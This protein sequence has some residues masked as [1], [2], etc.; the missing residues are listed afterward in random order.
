MSNPLNASDFLGLAAR[1]KTEL[2]DLS[3]V[4]RAGGV[5]IRELTAAQR[6][7][8]M[9]LGGLVTVRPDNSTT[10]DASMLTTGASVRI[11]AMSLVTDEGGET[12]M[13]KE[14][15]REHGSKQKA[16]NTLGELPAA[17]VDLLVG[18]I[19]RLSRMDNVEEELAAEK[20]G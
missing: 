15:I 20:N 18:R 5:W 4:G 7:E 12:P 6:D 17:V 1:L 14:W 19:R 11:L 8:V 9:K 16:L 10:F 2:V 3:E 13:L